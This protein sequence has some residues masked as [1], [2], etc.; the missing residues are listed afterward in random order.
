MTKTFTELMID[1]GWA[2][3]KDRYVKID[4]FFKEIASFSK[5][6]RAL[7]NALW[8]A[9]EAMQYYGAV[10]VEGEKALTDLLPEGHTLEELIDED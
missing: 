8:L 1:K 6:E 5:T 3:G 9:V 7:A 10:F 4:G 2:R